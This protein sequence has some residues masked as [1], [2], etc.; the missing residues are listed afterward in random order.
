MSKNQKWYV[1]QRQEMTLITMRMVK[2][3]VVACAHKK[4]NK[5]TVLW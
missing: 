3:S 1:T 2:E 4:D 5:K